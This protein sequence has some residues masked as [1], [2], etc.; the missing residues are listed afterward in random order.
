M[1]NF[2][3][4][5]QSNS[6]LLKLSLVQFLNPVPWKAWEQSGKNLGHC[7]FA[8]SL[9]SFLSSFPLSFSPY[10][11]PFLFSSFI[12]W[13]TFYLSLLMGLL[14]PVFLGS[15]GVGVAV[16]ERRLL[17][18]RGRVAAIECQGVGVAAIERQKDRGFQVQKEPSL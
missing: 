18:Q 4:R 17:P 7:G 8:S 15:Q 14:S 11:P 10:F 2:L 9:P 6:F 13:D 1:Q 3:C 12:S 5:L 16:I